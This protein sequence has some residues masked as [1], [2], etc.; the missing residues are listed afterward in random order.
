MNA[1]ITAA[2]IT[3][4]IDRCIHLSMGFFIIVL[5]HRTTAS[6]ASRETGATD[7]W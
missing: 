2:G 4:D 5:K 3:I 6:P 7:K 1:I